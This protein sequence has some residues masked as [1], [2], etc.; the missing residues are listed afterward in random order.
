M[1]RKFCN[2]YQKEVFLFYESTRKTT[3]NIPTTT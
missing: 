2:K 1:K 3:N